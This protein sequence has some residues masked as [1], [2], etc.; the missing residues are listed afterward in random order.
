[1]TD[2]PTTKTECEMWLCL[3]DEGDYL[4][5][6]GSAEDAIE[7]CRE[8]YG[9]QSFR[10]VKITVSMARPTCEAVSVDVP[11]EAGETVTAVA[12]E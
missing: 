3:N 11:D 7:A 2:T 10:T 12:A 5:D 8:N 4:V 9:G 1:M 6:I